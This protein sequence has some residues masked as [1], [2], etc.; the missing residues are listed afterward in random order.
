M[1]V[2]FPLLLAYLSTINNVQLVKLIT[3]IRP[4]LLLHIILLYA[5][6]ICIYRPALL[7]AYISIYAVHFDSCFNK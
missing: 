3:G 4:I 5:T 7:S 6:A 1:D 2:V